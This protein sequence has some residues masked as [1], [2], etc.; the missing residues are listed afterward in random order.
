MIPIVTVLGLDFAT[1]LGGA[2]VTESIFAWP[3]VGRLVVESISR[4]D[5][6]VVQAAVFLIALIYVLINLLVDVLYA[7]LNPRVRFS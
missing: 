3:G 5:F 2:V 4:R 6:P 7:Y 1:L